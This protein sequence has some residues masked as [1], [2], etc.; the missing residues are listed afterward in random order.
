MRSLSW[1]GGVAVLCIMGASSRTL[2]ATPS[3]SCQAANSSVET[4][5]CAD[6]RLAYKTLSQ[7]WDDPGR[8]QSLVAGQRRWLHLRD[9]VCVTDP[10]GHVTLADC[11]RNV[12]MQRLDELQASAENDENEVTFLNKIDGLP[13]FPYAGHVVH[14][15]VERLLDMPLQDVFNVTPADATEQDVS[16]STCREWW[17]YSAAGWVI[18][19]GPA[20]SM[21]GEFARERGICGG[22]EMIR[23]ARPAKHGFLP[24]LRALVD[25]RRYQASFIDFAASIKGVYSTDKETV[26]AME[27]AGKI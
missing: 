18:A 27:K 15:D 17:A 12:L 10:T 25:L 23:L 20:H 7:H 13:G 16:I 4:T 26:G 19:H 14:P 9:V 6:E 11:L 3:F 5:I 1:L 2:A 21:G 22:I 8:H 24:G